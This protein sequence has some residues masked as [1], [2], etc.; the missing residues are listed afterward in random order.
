ML[1]YCVKC[2]V[3]PAFRQVLA[4][5]A[6]P[7]TRG[8]VENFFLS[9]A[10]IFE[11]W[12]TR[13]SSAHTQRAY[14]EDVMALVKFLGL[15]WPREAHELLRVSLSDVRD[16]RSHLI[17]KDAAPKTLNRRIS[18]VSSFYKYLAA[19]AAELRLPITVPNPAHAQF[20][21]EL[22]KNPREQ[23][24]LQ[25]IRRARHKKGLS[26]AAIAEVLNRKKIPVSSPR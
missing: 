26:L 21:E 18:S 14:R 9:V 6:T 16:F 19:A 12:V 1:L 11:S 4:G 8:R 22:L 25:A 13:R 15:D 3:I 20:I 2:G 7:Q 24:V 5:T 17:Q 10:S 23:K